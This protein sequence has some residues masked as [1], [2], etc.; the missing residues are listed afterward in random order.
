M[1]MNTE[2]KIAV[3]LGNRSNVYIGNSAKDGGKRRRSFVR[4]GGLNRRFKVRRLYSVDS[5]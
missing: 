3:V 2:I 1:K 5:L 4:Y